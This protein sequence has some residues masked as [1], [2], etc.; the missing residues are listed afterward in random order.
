MGRRNSGLVMLM[1]IEQ[2][3]LYSRAVGSKIHYC[4]KKY[5][6]NFEPGMGQVQNSRLY[7]RYSS[8][9][10]KNKANECKM[11]INYI[12]W[13]F[14]SIVRCDDRISVK[15]NAPIAVETVR[16]TNNHT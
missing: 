7:I 3:Q 10:T 13:L 2:I 4:I 5:G 11:L 8:S 1:M 6:C 16:E 9:S 12:L 14:Y 15:L